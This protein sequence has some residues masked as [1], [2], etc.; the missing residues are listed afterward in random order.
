MGDVTVVVVVGVMEGTDNDQITLT[1]LPA[2][3][4]DVMCLV[5]AQ[6]H[7]SACQLKSVFLDASLSHYYFQKAH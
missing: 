2:V 1:S 3:A 7:F 6:C 5:C 4:R